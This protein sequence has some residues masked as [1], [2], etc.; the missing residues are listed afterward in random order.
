MQIFDNIVEIF[1]IFF[2]NCMVIVVLLSGQ[3][4][5]VEHCARRDY[6]K[7]CIITADL[8]HTLQ[9]RSNT[10]LLKLKVQVQPKEI[11][12]GNQTI[13]VRGRQI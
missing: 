6:R 2:E 7:Y 8:T 5:D 11:L 3:M 10:F 4:D 13:S 1:R 9:I 12:N